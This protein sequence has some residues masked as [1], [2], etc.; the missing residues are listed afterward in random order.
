MNN[1][2]IGT[3]VNAYVISL[4]KCLINNVEKVRITVVYKHAGSY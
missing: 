4:Y 1:A 3:I 2:F